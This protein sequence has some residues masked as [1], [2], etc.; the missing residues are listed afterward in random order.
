MP[1]IDVRHKFEIPDSLLKPA[2]AACSVTRQHV[3]EINLGQ[4]MGNEFWQLLGIQL[5]AK[6][7]VEGERLSF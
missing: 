2:I 3:K 7:T 1:H 6:Q 4:N 5:V